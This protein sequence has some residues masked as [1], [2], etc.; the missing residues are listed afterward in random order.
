M[1]GLYDNVSDSKHPSSCRAYVTYKWF[2]LEVL[3][4]CVE[5]I[6]VIRGK[7]LRSAIRDASLSVTVIA[8]Y[9]QQ[10]VLW[11]IIVSAF[12]VEVACMIVILSLVTQE[13]DFT[14]ECH[15]STSPPIFMAYWYLAP[16]FAYN[17]GLTNN[18][19][20]RGRDV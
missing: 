16:P 11:T 8:L 14:E 1:V 6:L 19:Q 7:I 15:T 13:Q 10:K 20:A 9:K 5:S 2:G 4:I 17:S 12:I 3:T 18:P